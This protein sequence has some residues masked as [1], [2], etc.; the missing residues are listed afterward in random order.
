VL[1]LNHPLSLYDG[2]PL[3]Q[4]ETSKLLEHFLATAEFPDGS[5]IRAPYFGYG[6]SKLRRNFLEAHHGVK[7]SYV[8][9]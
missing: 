5:V 3:R 8:S 6:Y 1:W 9:H 7:C 4:H 2:I